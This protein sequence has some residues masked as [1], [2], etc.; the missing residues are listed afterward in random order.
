MDDDKGEGA[1]RKRDNEFFEDGMLL[2]FM[3]TNNRGL[4]GRRWDRENKMFARIYDFL[5][6][7]GEFW[8]C[9]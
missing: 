1:E 7:P 2:C 6:I 4:Q 9:G 3:R 8:F 5:W